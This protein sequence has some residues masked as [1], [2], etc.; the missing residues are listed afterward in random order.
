MR[1]PP[2]RTRRWTRTQYDRLVEIGVLG[3][4]DRVELLD[5]LLVV[6]E[7]QGS[8][9]VTA[10]LRTRVALERAFGPGFHA[11]PQA[12]VAL[13]DTSEPEPD[14]AIVRG[15]ITDYRDAHPSSPVLVVEV[16]DSTLAAD[17][18]RKGL[19]YARAG[20]TDYWILNLVDLVL[21]VYR[22]PH[23]SPTGRWA[24]RRV[25]V[26][27]PSASISPLAAPNARVRVADLLP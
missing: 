1:I 18:V 5:G 3:R 6:R 14:V 27:R 10:V 15:R 24:Y 20:V 9:H 12:P 22:G 23:R 21:E 4:D 26:L 25:R 16:A 7:P 17:R 11:R 13:D 2:V 8:R 19:L